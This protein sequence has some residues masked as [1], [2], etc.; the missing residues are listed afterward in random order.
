MSNYIQVQYQWDGIDPV[1]KKVELLE[2]DTEMSFAL[3]F[4]SIMAKGL[5]GFGNQNYEL[6]ITTHTGE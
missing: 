6:H 3:R 5:D 2:D 4:E 1:S